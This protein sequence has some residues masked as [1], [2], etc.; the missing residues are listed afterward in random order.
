MWELTPCIIG[1]HQPHLQR[2]PE[3]GVDTSLYSVVDPVCSVVPAV[4]QQQKPFHRKT[5]RGLL[6]KNVPYRPLPLIALH[7]TP[8]VHTH[9]HQKHLWNTAVHS[10][11][12]VVFG[13]P[14]TENRYTVDILS[15]VNARFAHSN[16]SIAHSRAQRCICLYSWS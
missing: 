4:L 7:R 14:A 13:V 8:T 6:A 12:S 11:D 1:T 10:G 15:R 3:R 5:R 16:R 2:Y 9:V